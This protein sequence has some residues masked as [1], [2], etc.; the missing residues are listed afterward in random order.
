MLLLMQRLLLLIYCHGLLLFKLS[1]VSGEG[2]EPISLATLT[3]LLAAIIVLLVPRAVEEVRVATE[4][5]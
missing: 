3:L 5:V 4:L 2:A 1:L